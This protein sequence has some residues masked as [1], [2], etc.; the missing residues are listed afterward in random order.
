MVRKPLLKAL[1]LGFNKLSFS[2]GGVNPILATGRGDDVF[3]FMSLYGGVTPEEVIKAVKKTDNIKTKEPADNRKEEQDMS[4]DNIQSSSN[5]GVNALA[6]CQLKVVNHEEA[7][8]FEELFSG[9]AQLKQQAS[10]NLSF[11][12]ELLK[13]ARF[14]KKTIKK[15]EREFKSTRDILEKLKSVSGF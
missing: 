14:A 11:A 5:A 15:Q 12:N 4:R 7:D 6:H 8:P 10:E 3:V 13:Q 1:E 2:P 9:I